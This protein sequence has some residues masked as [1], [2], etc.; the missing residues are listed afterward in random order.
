MLSR[1][2]GVTLNWDQVNN[3]GY[4]GYATDSGYAPANH[5]QEKPLSLA[6]SSRAHQSLF[7]SSLS[8]IIA[9]I[10]SVSARIP[11][12]T[13]SFSS[14]FKISFCENY[15]IGGSQGS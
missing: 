1:L 5:V 3:I 15:V 11:F 4:C 10:S 9:H 6:R 13:I 8:L 12:T 7:Q 14:L 2:C